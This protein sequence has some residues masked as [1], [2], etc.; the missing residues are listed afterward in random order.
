MKLPIQS[1]SEINRKLFDSWI[2]QIVQNKQ[3]G[4]NPRSSRQ[5][6]SD[7]QQGWRSKANADANRH[8]FICTSSE[9]TFL[10]KHTEYNHLVFTK[11]PQ[12]LMARCYL[13][14][15]GFQIAACSRKS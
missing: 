6:Y 5:V 8:P 4:P 1:H 13:I 10:S 2:E 15:F 9:L 12:F 7:V 14:I 3:D 11:T